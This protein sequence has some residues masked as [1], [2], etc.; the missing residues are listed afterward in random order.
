M[1]HTSKTAFLQALDEYCLNDLRAGFEAKGWATFA[2]FAFSTAD[3]KGQDPKMFKE[4][5]VDILLGTENPRT[6]LI[7]KLRRL[8]AQSY[9]YTSQAMMAE[10]DPK[11]VHEKVH[12]H[13]AD[14]ASRTQR[15]WDRITGW[16]LSGQNMPSQVLIDKFATMLAKGVVKYIPWDACTSKEQE[17]LEEPA[18][19]GFRI[20]QGMIS[21]SRTK[22]AL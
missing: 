13:P 22:T 10:A 18:V 17:M 19:K 11:D 2:D 20:T 12:M 21:I 7:P 4:E 9:I 5:V 15:L 3:P 1:A 8:Y 14:R 16:S 6:E